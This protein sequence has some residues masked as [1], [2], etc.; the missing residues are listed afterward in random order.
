G[1]VERDLRE[2][3][4][5]LTVGFDLSGQLPSTLELT[6]GSVDTLVAQARAAGLMLPGGQL[7]PLVRQAVLETTPAYRV[8]ALQR[9]LVDTI[10]AEGRRLD[11]VAERLALDGL[12][13]ARV[14]RTLELA[15]DS[16]LATRPTLAATFY[17]EAVTAG[18]DERAVAARR[19]QAASAVGDL[20]G[21]ARIVDDLVSH[22]DAPD[23]ARAVDV[24]A[25]VWAQRG[26]L[27]DSAEMYRWLGPDRIGASAALA[28]VTMIGSGDREGA[29]T[30]LGLP[31]PAAPP[32]LRGIAVTSMARG[33]RDSV[34]SATD[35]ALRELI[36]ASDTMTASG[37]TAPL[38]ELPAALAAI[39]ALHSGDLGVA[40]SVIDAALA[41]GQCGPSAR[42]HLLLLRAWI[43]M[44]QDRADLAHAA[45]TQAVTAGRPLSPRNEVLLWALKVGL[46]RRAD[47]AHGLARAWQNARVSVLHVPVDLFSLLP[48]GEFN[49]AATRMRDADR[50]ASQLADAWRLLAELG[51]PPLWSIPLHWSAVHAAIL[52]ERPGELAPHAAALVRASGESHLASVLATA[53]RTWL[54]VLAGDFQVAAVET[55]ARGLASVGMTWDGSRLAG[56]AA[57]R[58]EERK[59]MARLLACAREL[60]PGVA[61]P[62]SHSD[63]RPESS[64]PAR[65]REGDLALSAREREVARLVLEG[66]TYEE[67]GEA[68]FIS[69]RTVEHHV[70]R[71][72]RRL[73]VTNRSE[74]LAR[75]RLALD[76]DDASQ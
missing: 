74:M 64:T 75:L 45:I 33:L 19:A 25:A 30:M 10:V 76:A 47:D 7:V 17:R 71:I 68:I 5:A 67:I 44:Q 46:A 58:T 53:G 15:G 50:L 12:K 54:A 21:A 4:L 20:D 40:D 28:A 16:A 9:A 48:L 37:S 23:L 42:P 26:M 2:L 24:A 34:L 35:Q 14:A 52:A 49:V 73:G 43:A 61:A 63:G 6:H 1:T 18:S 41:G 65:A 8:C 62:T 22:D 72:R 31:S 39:V 29:E 60:R 56:H 11:D 3:L 36:R 70:A 55:A 13:D 32:T 66:K 51:D 59:D 38:P 57:P 69:P 27:A